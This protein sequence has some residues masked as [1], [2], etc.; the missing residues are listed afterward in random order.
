MSRLKLCTYSFVF[1]ACLNTYGSEFTADKHKHYYDTVVMDAH[2]H[3][4]AELNV[5]M[6]GPIVDIE[7]ITPSLN[8]TGFEHKARTKEEETAVAQTEHIL[9]QHES[10]FVFSDRGCALKNVMVNVSALVEANE[11]V[12][13]PDH[14]GSSANDSH[15][16]V[17]ALYQYK[18]AAELSSVQVNIFEYFPRIAQIRSHWAIRSQQGS[19]VLTKQSR[20]IGF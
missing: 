14:R 13:S 1:L 11:N 15:S 18:C 2:V 16:E 4:V 9:L 12:D 5:V 17:T 10:I 7:L 6:E 3:G 19:T 8:L 20:T